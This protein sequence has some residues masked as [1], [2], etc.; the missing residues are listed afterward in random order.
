MADGGGRRAAAG[1][2]AARLHRATL[3]AS[4]LCRMGR[5]RV[6]CTVTE[7]RGVPRWL[8]GN[9]QGWVTAEYSM[10]PG[11]TDRR[12]ER[13]S[14]AGQ[15]SGS[16]PGDP[17]PD[18][19]QPAGGRRPPGPRRAHPLGRLR[20]APGRRR[21]ANRGHHRRLHG[22]GPRL[23]AAPQPAATSTRDPLRDS[24]AAVSVGIVD[25]EV[26]LDLP[27]EEDAR[28]EVDMN[29]VATGTGRF[30]EVQG[31]GE[32]GDLQRGR[33]RSAHRSRA[34][35]HRGARAHPRERSRVRK[36]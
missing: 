21:H 7:E 23:P 34:A 1:R 5:T 2:A 25:G 10:L 6:L 28:A 30:V 9:G 8:Q 24:V 22:A 17:A 31:T 27:Y 11:A 16:H 32:G 29:V 19:P 18:R 20:R 14:T 12:G 3:S 33:A 15:V 13:E 35:R 26:L 36:R 4:V